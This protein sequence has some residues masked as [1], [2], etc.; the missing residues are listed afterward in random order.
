MANHKSTIQDLEKRFHQ[1]YVVD[2]V[3]GCWLWQ[4]AITGSGYGSVSW[5]KRT[6]MAH[7]VSVALATGR[8]PERG[9]DV[10]HLC[11]VRAC[12]NP[13]HL[14]IVT[15]AENVTR[16]PGHPFVRTDK[17]KCKSGRH[18]WVPENLVANRTECR[19]CANEKA[20]ERY[21]R[22]KGG[23]QDDCD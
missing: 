1:K 4:G 19:L 23:A 17:S 22:G 11:R 16:I 14:E 5:Q 18:D 8:W 20:R 3:T 2:A 9:E 13:E 7:R 10:D 6:L 15:R 12:V 21:A